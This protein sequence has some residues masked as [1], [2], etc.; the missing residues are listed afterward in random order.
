MSRIMLTHAPRHLPVSL[1]FDVRQK[2]M[3][4][5]SRITPAMP[6]RPCRLCLAL[7][8]DSV[9]ADFDADENGR[10]YLRRIS[11]DGYGCCHSPSG[12]GKM[13]DSD[14]SILLGEPTP[15]QIEAVLLG[16]FRQNAGLLWIDALEEHGLI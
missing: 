8:D 15:H 11:F 9:F 7:Q 6:S 12:I 2:K 10:L 5:E 1:I 13:S 3:P 16:Y 14:T 4:I